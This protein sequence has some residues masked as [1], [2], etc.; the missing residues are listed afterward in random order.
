MRKISIKRE[1]FETQIELE[2]NLDGTGKREIKTKVGFFNHMLE[3]FAKHGSFDLRC[4]ANG[5][6]DVDY[7]HLVEDTGI[8][9]GEAIKKALGDKRGIK[10]YG[11]FYIPMMETLTRTS[12]D[13]SGRG[14]LS[15]NCDFKKE[16][17]GEFDTELVE[18]FFYS[19]AYNAGI[20]LH[21]DLIRGYNTHHIVESFFKS[22]AR[23]LK[24]ACII[25]GT[26]IPSTKGKI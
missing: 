12:L 7:H 17:V 5:D 16:K 26:E 20:N 23:A 2:I 8:V 3:L 25:E 21:M 19:V 13:L 6:I 15:F 14:F 1:T 10:R 22:F 9:L 4:E 18:E 24:E 11:T